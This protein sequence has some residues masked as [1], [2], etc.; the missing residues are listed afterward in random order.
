MSPLASVYTWLLAP[1]Q[2]VL[3]G[4]KLAVVDDAAADV[5]DELVVAAADVVNELVVAAADVVNELVVAAADVVDVDKLE[6]I[7]VKL[8]IEVEVEAGLMLF[9]GGVGTALAPTGSH[10]VG[11]SWST[12]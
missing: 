4:S 7:L 8:E 5:V 12:R 9:A 10:A 2:G 11:D 6:L 1:G 3:T